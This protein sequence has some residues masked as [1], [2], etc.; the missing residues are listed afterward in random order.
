MMNFHEASENKPSCWGIPIGIIGIFVVLFLLESKIA[1]ADGLAVSVKTGFSTLSM[2]AGSTFAK[3]GGLGME[4]RPQVNFEYPNLSAAV[5]LFFQGRL[6]SLYGAF[7]LTRVG[8]GIYYYPS[9]LALSNTILD[10]GVTMSHNRFAPFVMGQVAF[11]SIAVT[12]TDPTAPISFNGL[13][14]GYQIGGGGELPIG[15]ET[16]LIVEFIYEGVLQGG[17][18]GSSGSGLSYSTVSGMLG[19]S[20]HR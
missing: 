9:G 11:A 3:D 2:S 20:I 1:H 17:T 14:I 12:D 8:A 13:G 6:G 19:F 15:S 7:P 4:V 5:S 16:S 10:N 18:T